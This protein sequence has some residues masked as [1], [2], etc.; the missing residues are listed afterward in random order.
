MTEREKLER[1]IYE[2]TRII[3]MDTAAL[4]SRSMSEVDTGFLRRA[5]ERRTAELARQKENLAA[6]SNQDARAA[7]R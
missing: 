3:G 2:L 1:E 5:L 6:L 4:R 7:G